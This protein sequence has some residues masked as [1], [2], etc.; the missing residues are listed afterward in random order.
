M[1]YRGLCSKWPA[2][3]W[4]AKIISAALP[5]VRVSI[6]TSGTYPRDDATDSQCPTEQMPLKKFLEH[7]SRHSRRRQRSVVSGDEGNEG[8]GGL[9][10]DVGS[11]GGSGRI[12]ASSSREH[13]YCHG[14]PLP[15]EL[16]VDCPLPVTLRKQ[17]KLVARRSLWISGD[18]ASSPLHY[19]LPSVLLCQ[20]R[21]R[22]R[23][24][25]YS[26]A[27]HDACRPRGATFPALTAQA[28]IARTRRADLDRGVQRNGLYVELRPGDA[29]LMPSGWWHEVES[30]VGAGDAGDDDGDDDELADT[31][32]SV[33]FNWPTIADAIQNFKPWKEHVSDYPVL[34]QGQV[35]AEFYGAEKVRQMPGFEA[36]RDLSVF[37]T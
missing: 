24:F 7:L 22:K 33:G 29:L 9:G 6:S 28:R 2:R 20:L 27:H 19:D 10:G 34:T 35:L 25:L 3:R 32:I 21:G 17:A 18:G 15:D 5:Q 13:Y 12:R 31:C 8:D 26:P 23:V 37:A 11:E 14:N 36:V 4:D 30:S 1:V 16:F